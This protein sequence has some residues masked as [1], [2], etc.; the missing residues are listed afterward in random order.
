MHDRELRAIVIAIAASLTALMISPD[1]SNWESLDHRSKAA[2]SLS[3][4][5]FA[6]VAYAVGF[7]S[8]RRSR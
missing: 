5:S 3:I 8:G 6:A 4:I 7:D 1:P 2:F